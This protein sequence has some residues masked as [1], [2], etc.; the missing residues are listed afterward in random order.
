VKRRGG[1]GS[2][3]ERTEGEGEGEERGDA[4]PSLTQIPGSTAAYSARL[5]MM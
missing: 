1:K 3:G 4:P 5:Y 2:E